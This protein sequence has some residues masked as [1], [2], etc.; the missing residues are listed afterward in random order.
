MV[1]DKDQADLFAQDDSCAR[2]HAEYVLPPLEARECPW[3]TRERLC[4]EIE[5][6]DSVCSQ[7]GNNGT[8]LLAAQELGNGDGT[9]NPNRMMPA[10]R[11]ECGDGHGM[12]AV[13]AGVGCGGASENDDE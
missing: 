2:M 1:G 11:P 10:S 5:S 4:A 3:L 8:L 7:R 13:G 9:I 6:W 12:D